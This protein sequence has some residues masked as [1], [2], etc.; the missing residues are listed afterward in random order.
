MTATRCP[1][2]GAEPGAEP[3]PE[4]GPTIPCL[5]RLPNPEIGILQQLCRTAW[6][7]KHETC[8]VKR[9]LIRER[10]SKHGSGEEARQTHENI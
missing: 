5:V 10:G 9:P 8:A 2:P 6:R 3:G 4:P 1:E 7:K